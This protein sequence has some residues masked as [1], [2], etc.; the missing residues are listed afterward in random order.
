MVVWGCISKT[1]S[2]GQVRN[3]LL[4][5]ADAVQVMDWQSDQQPG[6]LML[7]ESIVIA[8]TRLQPLL[9]RVRINATFSQ[10]V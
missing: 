8:L 3:L 2:T 1:S 10:S 4:Y 5:L 9:E 6:G 7:V